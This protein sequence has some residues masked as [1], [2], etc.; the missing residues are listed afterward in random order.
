MTDLAVSDAG[1]FLLVFS[2]LALGM[3]IV[4]VIDFLVYGI[5]GFSLLF[6]IEKIVFRHH[7][8]T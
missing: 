6:W 5:S 2:M 8:K 7:D 1:F 3:A 4:V